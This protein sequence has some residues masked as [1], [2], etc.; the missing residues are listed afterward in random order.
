M[1]GNIAR[2]RPHSRRRWLVIGLALICVAL[3]QAPTIGWEIPQV[4][5]FV[6]AFALLWLLPAMAWSWCLSGPV[7]E[8]LAGGLGLAFVG[9]GLVTL[10]LHLIPGPFPTGVAAVAYLALSVLPSL[11][12]HHHAPDPERRPTW[13]HTAVAGVLLVAALVRVTNLNYSE[14]Q[15]DEAVV[16]QRAD[17]AL[18]G[19][20][21]ELFLH[22]KGPVEILVPMSLWALTGTAVEWQM[23]APF[24]LAG[25]LSVLVVTCLGARW[26]GERTKPST[27]LVAGIVAGLLVAIN[28]FLVAFSRIV[29]YQNL[30]ISMGGLS[31]LWLLRYRRQPRPSHLVLAAVFLAYGLLAHYDAILFAPAGLAILVQSVARVGTSSGSAF[32]QHARNL[33]IACM[34]GTAILASFYLPYV[35]DPMFSRTFSYLA[36]GRLGGGLFHSSLVSVWR[37]STFYN[38]LIL[39]VGMALLVVVAAVLRLGDSA[40]WLMFAIPFLFYCFVVADPRTHVYTFYP[41]AAILAGGAL[42]QVASWLT[43]RWRGVLVATAS[44]WYALGA[45]YAVIAFVNHGV[46]YKRAWPE[47]RLAFYPVPFSDDELPPYGHFGFPYRA[48]WKAVEQL[49]AEGLLRGTYASNE[50]PE[51]TTWYVRSATRTMCGHPDVYVIAEK[52]QDEI[53]IDTDELQ[54]E[55]TLVARVEVGGKPKIRVY[56]RQAPIGDPLVLDAADFAAAYDR[57]TTIGAQV[58]FGYGMDQVGSHPAGQAFGGV[59][60]LLGFD[61]Q[62]TVQDSRPSVT[63]VLYWQALVSPG[64]NYQVF[65]HLVRQEELIAQNDSA[66][67]CAHAPTS[68]WEAGEVIRDEHTIDLD[69]AEEPDGLDVYVGMYDLLT[70]DRLPV[71]GGPS[72]RVLLTRLEVDP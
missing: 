56:Q 37:M 25:M 30:V 66:P 33:L 48:G 7:L 63:V 62:T 9:S 32:T 8:R 28:G 24:A 68:L 12:P 38:A 10:L 40:A 5:R 71:D 26:A 35:T 58:P 23:R 41:G 67:A 21:G 65:T 43:S 52:V 31:L 15:G 16:M 18:A 20:D 50:E 69:P 19:D 57:L 42:S 55:Y 70:L 49:F 34:V 2:R 22:Q 1:I 17:L 60:R 47:S 39:V 3:T 44:V 4:F 59:A 54:S 29:Q 45:G 14:F 51:I 53:A 72:D 11:L 46:E 36:G 64:R 27:A 6:A 13:W 61:V